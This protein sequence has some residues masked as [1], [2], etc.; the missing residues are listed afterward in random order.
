M[1][2]FTDIPH[3]P[4]AGFVPSTGD[5]VLAVVALV[6]VGLVVV[7]GFFILR[8]IGRK[9]V[10]METLTRTLT[11]A[12]VG[13]G[14]IICILI[15]T[16]GKTAEAARARQTNAT[17]L[18]VWA[19]ARYGVTLTV[20]ESQQLLTTYTTKYSNDGQKI[21]INVVNRAGADYLFSGLYEL[22]LKN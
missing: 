6:A 3:S 18:I 10:K 16:V 12:L 19:Q 22:P 4:D 14:L 8:R 15:P 1:K 11:A 2:L 7:I 9:N 21:T 13:F 5:N 17:A 20:K